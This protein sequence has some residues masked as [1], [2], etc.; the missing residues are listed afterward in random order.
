MSTHQNPAAIK[1]ALQAAEPRLSA[2]LAAMLTV[3]AEALPHDV[4]ERLRFAREQAVA[5][6]RERR[7]LAEAPAAAPA[8]I[9]VSSGGLGLLADG[10]P[11]WQRLASL[12]P[13]VLLVS[14]LVA[15]DQWSTREQV[16]AAAEID[17]QLLA[18]QLPP[19]AYGD[20][21]FAEFL[22]SAPPQ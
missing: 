1:A 16:L 20:P 2:R 9:G 8:V 14:G 12:L 13:L 21:G 5:R 15:I 10:A 18:D 7:R 11:W 4:S 19:D 17:A 3:R 22:R 6:A